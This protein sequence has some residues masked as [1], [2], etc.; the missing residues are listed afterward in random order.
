MPP[1]NEVGRGHLP[2]PY[3]VGRLQPEPMAALD[4][5]EAM[6]LNGLVHYIASRGER[7]AGPVHAVG[8]R[9]PQ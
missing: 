9:Q 4:A 2:H 8:V 7:D 6:R 5:A 1:A 3:F